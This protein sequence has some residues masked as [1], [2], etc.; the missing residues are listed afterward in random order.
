VGIDTIH[1]KS[2]AKT[3]VKSGGYTLFSVQNKARRER[4]VQASF[5][6]KSGPLR[7]LF[8]KTDCANN[9]RQ[10]A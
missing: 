7:R 2:L 3:L 4:G 8:A 10:M 5:S 9:G 1:S 6:A